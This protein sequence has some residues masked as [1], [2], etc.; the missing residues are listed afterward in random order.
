MPI[1]VHLWTYNHQ[2]V[3]ISDQVE[4]FRSAFAQ[5]GYSATVGNQPHETALNVVIEN[6][7]FATSAVLS[8][9][10]ERTGKRV[11]VVMTEHID[12]VDGEILMH[13]EKLWN[14]NDYMHPASQ[15]ERLRNLVSVLKYIKI[16]FILG[17]LPELRNISDF[18]CGSN[19]RPIAFPRLHRVGK[20]IEPKA[21]LMFT[22][23]VTQ[24]RG[25]LLSYLRAMDLT[26]QHPSGLVDHDAR[27]R[28]NRKSRLVLN[29]PQRKDWRWLSSMR[30]FAALRCGRATVSL[31]TDD[32][33]E[34]AKCT[35]QINID[36]A[37][38]EELLTSYVNDWQGLY[39]KAH[40]D[41]TAMA[42]EFERKHPFPHDLMEFWAITDGIST[43][44]AN[45][46]SGRGVI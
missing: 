37:G 7:S 43:R 38:W 34:M 33:C 29:L 9:F 26:V 6:F 1:N 45:G 10:C 11:A 21:D 3:G 18:M 44:R 22:G 36:E 16:F 4:Y 30:I 27:D 25:S 31:G 28:L 40:A 20:M 46:S 17:D 14:S 35:Y 19:V 8:E 2:M 24:Y 15:V 41:Y 32:T 13:G 5:N 42:V 23:A 39:E 12:F